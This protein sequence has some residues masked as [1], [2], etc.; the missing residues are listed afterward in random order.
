MTWTPERKA[1]PAKA[2][3]QWQ[4]WLK[5]TEAKTAEGNEVV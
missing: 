2:I 5:S 3:R 1:K 4:T